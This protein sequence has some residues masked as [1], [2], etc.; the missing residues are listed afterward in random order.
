MFDGHGPY[1]HMVA[2]KVRDSLPVLLCSQWKK[3]N[4]ISGRIEDGNI[5]TNSGEC[6]DEV[7]CEPF[8]VEENDHI[9]PEVYQSLKQS[10]LKAFKV[11]SNNLVKQVTL[12]AIF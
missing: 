4:S 3:A 2:K 12:H 1:G 8:E 6:L 10:I 7:F 9:L 11:Q 5:S